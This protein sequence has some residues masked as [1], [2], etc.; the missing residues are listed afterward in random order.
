M[1]ILASQAMD[2]ARGFT[3]AACIVPF[4][5]RRADV[6]SAPGEH[7]KEACDPHRRRSLHPGHPLHQVLNDPPNCVGGQALLRRHAHKALSFWP[8]ISSFFKQL[9]IEATRHMSADM[10]TSVFIRSMMTRTTSK[11]EDESIV[12]V[13]VACSVGQSAEYLLSV[14]ADD[15]YRRFFRLTPGA[16]G[17]RLVPAHL[18]FLDVRR[19]ELFDSQWIPKS[20]LSQNMASGSELA[21]MPVRCPSGVAWGTGG[22]GVICPGVVLEN[23]RCAADAFPTEFTISIGGDN[24]MC[25]V[26]EAGTGRPT[27]TLSRETENPAIILQ[28]DFKG[29]SRE[30]IAVLL[31]I[32]N[33]EPFLEECETTTET[34]Y[35]LQDSISPRKYGK[36]LHFHTVV[37]HLAL[38]RLRPMGRQEGASPTFDNLPRIQT[39]QIMLGKGGLE[40]RF[41]TERFPRWLVI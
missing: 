12:L 5:R 40:L 19:Y 7:A 8:I 35:V 39:R 27:A 14:D 32:F 6:S 38:L 11:T 17:Y 10:T 21:P 9:D 41:N 16:I 4:C 31:E 25:Q 15:R 28:R 22:L 18:I 13:S 26:V 34:H 30:S 33:W 23:M 2:N 1:L 24:Y 3:P 20:L 36:R 37:Y 29:Q